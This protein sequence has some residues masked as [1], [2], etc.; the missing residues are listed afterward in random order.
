MIRK[1][2]ATIALGHVVTATPHPG[3]AAVTCPIELPRG[4]DPF[5]LE[6]ADFVERIDNPYWPMRPGTTWVYREA[7]THGNQQR[8]VVKVKDRTRDIL[9]IAAT[10]VRDTVTEDGELVEDTRDWYAQDV[11]GNVW[12][13]GERTEEY[14]GGVPVTTAGSWE[15]GV[16]G[17]RG[18]VFMPATPEVGQA[19]WN[20]KAPGIAEDW[21]KVVSTSEST[22]VPFGSFSNCVE[23][24]ERTPL[25]PD[26]VGGKLYA[27]D[28]GLVSETA[29]QEENSQLTKYTK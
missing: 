18:G 16:N 24:E 7:D 27:K 26:V 11:C 9:G 20:E 1:L 8:V 21:F 14:E 22:S 29:G 25:E 2:A 3:V 23:T 17:A 15:H 4:V 12:Y 13:L 5:T 6:P 28:V 19:F 10:V